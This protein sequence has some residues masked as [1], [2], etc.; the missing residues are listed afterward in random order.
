MVVG[1]YCRTVRL[2]LTIIVWL[3]LML[4]KNGISLSLA[5]S[6]RLGTQSPVR[7]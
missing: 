2:S 6:R 4:F 5:E 7:T 1:G 3:G